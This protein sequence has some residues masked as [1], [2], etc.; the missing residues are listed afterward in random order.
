MKK[1]LP[2]R[3]LKDIESYAR[4][5]HIHKVVLFGS[6]AKGNYTERSDVDIAV[7]GGDFDSFYWD[8]KENAHSLLMLDIVNMDDN[9]S[10][11]LKA[12]IAKDGITIYE[13]A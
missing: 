9:I 10:D 8:M 1:Y 4:K 13:K 12:S 2:E 11:E 6:R 5:H 3:L 7:S